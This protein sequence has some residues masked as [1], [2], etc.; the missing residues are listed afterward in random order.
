M[1]VVMLSTDQTVFDPASPVR[2]RMEEYARAFGTLSIIVLCLRAPGR[3]EAV[4]EALFIYPTNSFSRLF[5]L[6]DAVR[7]AKRVEKAD[8]V[9]AQDPFETGLAGYW[10]SQS[11]GIPLHVQVHTN[12]LASGFSREHWPLNPIRMM[13]AGFVLPRAAGIRAVSGTIKKAIETRYRPNAAISVLPIF[14]DLG[15]FRRVVKTKHPKFGTALL[16]VSRLES[17]KRVDLAIRAL[18][19]VRDAGFDAGLTVVGSGSEE[20]RLKREAERLHLSEWVEFAGF[21]NNL[22]PYYAVADV[23][24]YP[25]APY[26][27]YGMAILEALAAGVPV[28]AED[29]G[30]ARRAGAEIAEGDF[31]EALVAFLRRGVTKGK[32]LYEPYTSKEEYLKKLSEDLRLSYPKLSA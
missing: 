25:G 28:L 5:S 27:G 21:Q 29:V 13:I 4:G 3:R 30:I 24:L 18:K 19:R 6:R 23:F 11:L 20:G 7:I 8:V 16:V 22:A 14:V 1:H 12:F 31:G 26:E 15:K 10:I 32:L 9:T 17:E 2:A